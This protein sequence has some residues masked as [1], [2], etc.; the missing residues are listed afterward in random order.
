MEN[1]VVGITSRLVGVTKTMAANY[2]HRLHQLIYQAVAD[3]APYAGEIEVNE[4]YFGDH[5]KGK[6]GQGAA[7][8]IPVLGLLKQGGKAY[9]VVIAGAQATALLPI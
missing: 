5:R 8:K 1:F 3:T 7:G 2:Y 6:R 4:S 9:A